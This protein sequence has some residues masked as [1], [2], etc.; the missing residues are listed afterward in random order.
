[1]R[2]QH[3]TP[4]AYAHSQDQN[5]ASILSVRHLCWDLIASWAVLCR[6]PR[7]ARG[8]T[9]MLPDDN[10]ERRMPGSRRPISASA[11]CIKNGD[12]NRPV[13]VVDVVACKHGGKWLSARCGRAQQPGCR[14]RPNLVRLF[15]L[16]ETARR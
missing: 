14:L 8:F 3:Y 13:P 1:M 12:L 10:D 4:Q 2:R 16:S 11:A 7:Q 9:I 5:S 15:R 6:M